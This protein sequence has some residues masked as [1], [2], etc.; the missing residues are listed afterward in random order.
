VT[1]NFVP[2]RKYVYGHILTANWRDVK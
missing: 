2:Y 1:D